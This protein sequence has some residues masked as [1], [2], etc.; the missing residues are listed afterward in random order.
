MRLVSRRLQLI[1]WLLALF[2]VSLITTVFLTVRHVQRERRILAEAFSRAQKWA[3][4][5]ASTIDEYLRS[6][7]PVAQSIVADLERGQLTGDNAAPRFEQL[8]QERPNLLGIGLFYEPY[9]WSSQ[10]RLYSCYVLRHPDKPVE[11]LNVGKIYDYTEPMHEWYLG[12]LLEGARWSEPLEG[13]A[14]QALLF[15]YSAP[16][17]APHGARKEGGSTQEPSGIVAVTHSSDALRE[18]IDGLRLDHAGY[19]F[20]ISPQGRLIVHPDKRLV[21]NGRSIFEIAWEREDSALQALAISALRSRRGNAIDHVDPLSG[22]S[23]WLLFEPI[24]SSGWSL[25]VVVFKEGLLDVA[26][27]RHGW[28]W[29][30]V[31]GIATLLFLAALASAALVRRARLALWAVSISATLILVLGVALAWVIERTWPSYQGQG[32][33]RMADEPTLQNFLNEYEAESAGRGRAPPIH[34]PTAIFVESMDFASAYEVKVTGYAWQRYRK[35]V[36][37]NLTR[38]LSLP[39]AVGELTFEQAYSQQKDGEEL[40]GFRFDGTLRQDFDYEAYPLDR[41]Q[42]WFRMRH[43]DFE[44]NVLLVPDL[45]S[46]SVTNPASLPGVTQ[47]LL[48]PGWRVVG[49]GFDYRQ[50]SYNTTFGFQARAAVEAE[51]ELHYTLQLERE[52]TSPFIVRFL[53]LFVVGSMLFGILFIGT[54]RGSRAAWFGFTAKDVVLGCAALFFVV[55]FDHAALR[56][57]L[58]SPHVMY[59][60]W[61]YL[62]MY[63]MLMGVTINSLLFATGRLRLLELGDN[64]LPKVLFGPAYLGAIFAISAAVF[65]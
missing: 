62:M 65:Y 15:M 24:E 39:E 60:E 38:G 45:S 13:K 42:V 31:A 29:V 51:P 12:P 30:L 37:A 41:Q 11:V 20:L 2:L 16:F 53:P 28:M 55:I 47:K 40:V 33:A 8:L 61:F 26:N 27:A 9:A 7:Q 18:I 48:L 4:Q 5:G 23:S 54:K 35:D 17:H 57:N 56:Q 32:V 58:A 22:Q 52:F 14:S 34:V 10:E 19:A 3:K 1:E 25:G 43:P 63:L 46:Y 36:H 6:I 64:L 44:R 49:A 21:L 59:M 50:R